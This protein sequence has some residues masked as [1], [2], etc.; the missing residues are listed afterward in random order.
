MKKALLLCASLL[1]ASVASAKCGVVLD[2]APGGAATTYSKLLQ[3]YNPEFQIDFRPGG[4]SVPAVNYLRNNPTFIYFGTAALFGERSPLPNPPIELYKI[5]LAAPIML[6]TNKPQLTMDDV[7]SKKIN[8]GVGNFNTA[9][10]FIAEQLRSLNPNIEIIATGGDSKALPLVM[11]GDLD[12]YAIS[13]SSGTQYLKNFPSLRSLLEVKQNE[14]TT[15]NDKKIVNVGFNAA[16]ISKYATDEQKRIAKECLDRAIS[17]PGWAKDIAELN[18][19]P[20]FYDESTQNLLMKNYVE[21]LK[22]YG[23]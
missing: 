4:L 2:V 11:N 19:V 16:F 12:F 6:I 18:V 14:V 22:V 9:N 13:G 8:I 5:L 1:L 15:I 21:F 23:K 10:H 3:K 20:T 7:L 17:N